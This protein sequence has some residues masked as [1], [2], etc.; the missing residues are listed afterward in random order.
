MRCHTPPNVQRNDPKGGQGGGGKEKA[1]C[2]RTWLILVKVKWE[3]REMGLW[4]WFASKGSGKGVMT[5]GMG[6]DFVML[7]HHLVTLPNAPILSFYVDI[8][9]SSVVPF[10]WAAPPFFFS[11]RSAFG[12]RAGI[13][14][15]VWS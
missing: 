15:A 3:Q 7:I 4:L 12:L 10:T 6:W 9:I 14:E 5:K 2:H 13:K 1:F 8:R 11:L